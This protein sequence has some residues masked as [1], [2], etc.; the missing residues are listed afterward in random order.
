MQWE[1]RISK[2]KSYYTQDIFDLSRCLIMLV[3]L[4]HTCTLNKGYFELV[5]PFVSYPPGLHKNDL[6]KCHT[7]IN[8]WKSNP[9]TVWPRQTVIWNA[10]DYLFVDSDY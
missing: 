2:S 3:F 10:C 7:M 8:M 9:A 5:I 1:I 6:V 4:L